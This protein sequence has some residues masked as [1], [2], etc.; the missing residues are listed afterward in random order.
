MFDELRDLL[1]QLRE[2]LTTGDIEPQ[3]LKDLC[4]H[5]VFRALSAYCRWRN[6]PNALSELFTGSDR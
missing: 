5:P 3:E 2:E 4:E 6:D 1:D